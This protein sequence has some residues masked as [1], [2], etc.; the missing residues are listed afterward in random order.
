M[1]SD[2]EYQKRRNDYP[3]DQGDEANVNKWDDRHERRITPQLIPRNILYLAEY[4]VAD[5]KSNKKEED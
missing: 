4:C 5:S 3:L 1:P 2:Y